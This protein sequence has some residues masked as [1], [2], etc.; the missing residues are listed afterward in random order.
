L[1]GVDRIPEHVHV[2]ISAQCGV[3][4]TGTLRT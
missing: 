1:G 4:C 2:S 3:P